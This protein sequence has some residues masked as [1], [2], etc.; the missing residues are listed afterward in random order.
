MLMETLYYPA[1]LGAGFFVV[2]SRAL[3]DLA[4]YATHVG[5]YYPI[6]LLVC[7]SISFLLT[8]RTSETHY[9][10]LLFGLDSIEALLLLAMF[11]ALGFAE[12]SQ[13][14]EDLTS[15]YRILLAIPVLQFVWRSNS[16]QDRWKHKWV[17]VLGLLIAALGINL[18][19]YAPYV[20]WVLACALAVLVFAYAK[21]L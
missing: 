5:F 11:T 4:N 15:F 7:F 1:V 14:M 13:R 12:T 2:A 17:V 18:R 3:G 16:G 10:P 8:T 20:D 21:A 9:K 19:F 6:V